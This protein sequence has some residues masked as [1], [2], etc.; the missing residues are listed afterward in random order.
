MFFCDV[1]NQ[2]NIDEGRVFL[3]NKIVFEAAEGDA[4]FQH[5]NVLINK[6]GEKYDIYI[7]SSLEYE[8]YEVCK[9][10]DDYM[11]EN[12]ILFIKPNSKYWIVMSNF[13]FAYNLNEENFE[14]K[15]KKTAKLFISQKGKIEII[16]T[17]SACILI[18]FENRGYRIYENYENH[19]IH[20]RDAGGVY[21][22]LPISYHAKLKEYDNTESF[23]NFMG[24]KK[25]GAN[26]F[27]NFYKIEEFKKEDYPMIEGYHGYWGKDENNN[28]C[29]L[30]IYGEKD[31]HGFEVCL[32]F[33]KPV[34]EI[35][36]C[37]R[38][39][40]ND[41][42][43]AAMDV[44]KIISDGKESFIFQTIGQLDMNNISLV[45]SKNNFEC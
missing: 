23:V 1:K 41:K 2:F 38:H 22:K 16:N 32:N 31:H 14:S 7:L 45:I 5:G 3:G 43:T 6:H 19:E 9:N 25:I 35:K 4:V 30:Y 40:L 8:L 15:K 11:Y 18:N 33:K 39:L 37:V 21:E 24:S 34:Q 10:A 13:E 20:I 29:G 17:D 42:R 27:C 36:F 12:G 44:W 28:I 26:T